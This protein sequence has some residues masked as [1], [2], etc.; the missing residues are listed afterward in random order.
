MMALIITVLCLPIS[1]NADDTGYTLPSTGTTASG[2]D[3]NWANASN[4]T[5]DNT[6]YATVTLSEGDE[7]NYLEGKDFGFSIPST[8]TIDGIE[9]QYKTYA[10]DDEDPQWG[11]SK[12]LKAGSPVGTSNP[13]RGTAYPSSLSTYT[14]GSST[15]LWGT[16]WTPSDIN[17]SGFGTYLSV[18][19]DDRYDDEF[20]VYF[21]KVKVYY[22]DGGT[23]AT[24]EA[25]TLGINF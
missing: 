3:G 20:R 9:V 17:D 23:S 2:N 19:G 13:S 24:Q 4:I 18:I 21:V 22:T 5:A 16:T 7:S 25:G 11:Y 6:Y 15:S 8:A 14:Y 12:L 1:A 10:V